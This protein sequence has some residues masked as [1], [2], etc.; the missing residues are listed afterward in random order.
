MFDP[1]GDPLTLTLDSGPAGMTVE[2]VDGVYAL[3][4]DTRNVAL[5]GYDGLLKLSDGRGEY[6][7]LGF[8]VEVV[9]S[10]ANTPPEIAPVPDLNA[11]LDKPLQYPLTA[12]DAED[13]PLE[14]TLLEGPDGLS[15][16]PQTGSLEWTPTRP[17][18]LGAKQVMVRVSDPLGGSD[19]VVFTVHTRAVNLPPVLKLIPSSN[20]AASGKLYADRIL[21]EDPEGGALVYTISGTD[22]NGN[23]I[24]VGPADL[25][26]DPQLGTIVCPRPRTSGR[27]TLP[28]RSATARTPRSSTPSPS[29][30]PTA[31]PRPRTARR[32]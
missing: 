3:K 8:T 19:T 28:S 22:P 29:S 16:H 5:G 27:T 11:T 4:W 31:R 14:W 32:R 2:E 12:G 10:S 1:D 21:A 15:V 20:T 25:W 13:D 26:I 6:A 30:S 7:L 24:A 17:E 23:P 18:D 9:A